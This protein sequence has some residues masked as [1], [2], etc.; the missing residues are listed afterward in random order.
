MTMKHS[1]RVN[2]GL[3]KNDVLTAELNILD[4]MNSAT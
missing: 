3:G 2:I 4:F 1:D